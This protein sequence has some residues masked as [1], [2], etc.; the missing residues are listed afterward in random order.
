MR[1]CASQF[2]E[3]VKISDM[4]EELIPAAIAPESFQ[5]DAQKVW[6]AFQT[7]RMETVF[8]DALKALRS[9]MPLLTGLGINC[10]W[11]YSK[12]L[13]TPQS[14]HSRR[15]FC[16]AVGPVINAEQVAANR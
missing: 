9:K 1:L 2:L 3:G 10:L 5:T 8:D 4:R 6:T 16:L 12:N 13:N 15:A 14:A 7:L 11:F